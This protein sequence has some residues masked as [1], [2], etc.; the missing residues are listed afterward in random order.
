MAERVII[1]VR[2]VQ[3][4]PR[5]NETENATEKKPRVKRTSKNDKQ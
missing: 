3:D 4:V 2:G 1:S 5:K